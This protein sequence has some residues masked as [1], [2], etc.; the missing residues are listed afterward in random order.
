MYDNETTCQLINTAKNSW[1]GVKICVVVLI[2]LSQSQTY[3]S[4]GLAQ[5][6]SP[7]ITA[8]GLGTHINPAAISPPGKAQYD[9][10][11]G[12][13]AGTNLFHSFG[14][15]GVP[16]NNIAN[17]LNESGASTSNIL[18]RVTGGNPSNIFGNI[19]TTGFGNANLFLM[20][21]AGFLF[22]P[23]ATVNVGG[24]ATFTTADYLRLNDGKLFHAVPNETA[25]GLLSAA[26]VA[27]FGFL[28]SNPAAITVQGSQLA[29]QP[30]QGIALVGGNITVQNGT[31]D[32]G[33]VQP[34]KLTAPGGQI[35]LAS[36]GSPGEILTGTLDQ[37]ANV[38]GQ[39]FGAL[40]TVQVTQ[41]S[42]I[43]SS[44]SGGGT[45]LIR[46]GRFVLDNSTISANVTAPAVG[47]PG[48]GIDVSVTQDAI[49]QNAG[50]LQTNVSPN[51]GTSAGGVRVSA[52]HIEIVGIPPPP[53]L[54]PPNPQ[55]QVQFTGIRSA[56]SG[57]RGGDITLE[58]NSISLENFAQLQSN[59]LGVPPPPTG[60][61][62]PQ[63]IGS[64]GNI[65]LTANQKLE[66]DRS[67]IT[68]V[69]SSQGNSAN[70][71]LTSTR[72]DVT[73]TNSS[74]T[75]SQT[76][77]LG[78]AGAITLSA[79]N[80][81]ILLD[82]AAVSTHIQ[83]PGA[84]GGSGGGIS[85][86][87]KNLTLV[88]HTPTGS[89]ISLDNFN[90]QVPDNI[91]VTLSGTLS[92]DGNTFIQTVARGPALAAAG[93]NITAHDVSVSGGA[94]LNTETKSS[95]PGGPLN[96]FAEN[97]QLTSGGQLKSGSTLGLAAG[98]APGAPPVTVIPSGRGGTITIQGLAGPSAS[99]LVDGSNSGI[100]TNAV[101]T[102]AGGNANISAQSVTVQNGGTMSASTSGTAPSAAGGSIGITAG[103]FTLNNGGSIAANST[104]P[105]NAGHIAINVGTTF[106]DNGGSVSTTA[107][108]GQGGNITVMAGQL[109]QLDNGASITASSTGPG[110]AGNI[111]I[112]AGQNFTSTNSSVTTSADQASGGNITVLAS[113]MIHLTNSQI[114]ASVQGAQT[115]VGGNVT[116]DPNFL[117]LQNSQILAQATQGQGGNI[118]ITANTFL[119]DNESVVSAS[120]QAGV[121]GTVSVQSPISQAGGKIVP[122]SKAALEAT[123]LLS[124]R[125]A[126]LAGGAYSSF[127]VAGREAVP[128]E[129]GGWL[130]SPLLMPEIEPNAVALDSTSLKSDALRVT[131]DDLVS[132]RR[133]PF[134]ISGAKLV[135]T[136]WLAGCGSNS[137]FD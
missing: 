75:S 77:G 12:T 7:P 113:D 48:A 54:P 104:G 69:S 26:P 91:T 18:G 34:A 55:P 137:S 71:N 128:T 44:G 99:V 93:L 22:G 6:S 109:V 65:N 87:A 53:S 130:A 74:F 28:G 131:A 25:D 38:N 119:P 126:A 94:F 17:F 86:T 100:F 95:G 41:K 72:G 42:V 24:M 27:A 106:Q 121:N 8:S 125:C 23:T 51:V 73:M 133:I 46:G 58:A 13:R 35:H 88:N 67:I 70:I 15:F 98:P 122:L 76:A 118:S 123:P 78:N 107:S 132:I 63:A 49:I 21:P 89:G 111:V 19:Q 84:V 37:A 68:S 81:N 134:S 105:A 85:F 20:N 40:G 62:S 52:D 3:V 101:G 114:N 116:I 120:S 43:D 64:A 102:G 39:S 30:G 124:Q 2:A 57:G 11:G 1:L 135:S 90:P 136:D 92:L 56:T 96:I 117:I 60:P 32:S 9:I 80:G 112:N 14:N 103:Q 50:V 16:N 97:V 10:T 5:V 115:T 33:T 129:P 61:P 45:V 127:V 82:T 83:G 79:P 59:A 31:L 66:M 29:A 108:Q 110:N 36:V 47:Q 4:L